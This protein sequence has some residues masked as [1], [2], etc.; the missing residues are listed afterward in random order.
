[1]SSTNL[2]IVMKVDLTILDITKSSIS[3][4]KV[5]QMIFI[6]KKIK[7]FFVIKLEGY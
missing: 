6:F 2:S 1:M 7:D 5:N 4:K 3:T